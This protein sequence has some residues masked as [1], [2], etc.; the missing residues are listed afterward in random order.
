MTSTLKKK[1]MA[2]F[3]VGDYDKAV[4]YFQK[5]SAKKPKSTVLKSFL[6]RAKLKSYQAHVSMARKYREANRKEEAIKEYKFALSVFPLNVKLEDEFNAYAEIKRSPKKAFVSEINPPVNL[7]VDTK[8]KISIKLPAAPIKKIYNILGKSFNIN[9]IFDKDFRDFVYGLEIE[10][11]G[12][13]QILNQLCMVSNSRYRVLDSTSIMVYPDT[14]FKRRTFDLQ[15]VKVFYLSNVKVED[16]KKNLM[17][18]FRDQRIQAQEDKNLNSIII[19]ADHDTLKDIERFL[20]NIDKVKSEVEIDLQI[21][22]VNR[23]IVNEMGTNFGTP[24]L[25]VSAGTADAEGSI[26]STFNVND[27]GDTKFSI[28]IPSAA[29]SFLASDDNTKI[30]SKPNLRG[31][32]GEEIS[33]KVGEE[34]P[35]PQTSFQSI[36]AGGVS[37]VPMTTYT[38]KPV[39]VDVK[40]TP[41]VHQNNEVTL[42]LKLTLKSVIG[43]IDAFPILGNRELENIIRLKEGETNI[44]GGFIED[45][46]RGVLAGLPGFSK[47]PLLGKLFG[48]TRKEIKQK[49]L[50]FSITPRVIRKL[51][52]SGSNQQA[53]WLNAQTTPGGSSDIQPGRSP[54]DRE[55]KPQASAN[56]IMIA[57]TN[58]TIPVNSFAHFT[59][60]ANSSVDISTLNVSGSVEGPK[61]AIQELKTDIQKGG[62]KVFKNFSDNSFDIGVSN[63]GVGSRNSILGQVKVKFLQKGTYIIKIDS[64]NAT[65]K[66]GKNIEFETIT[67]E[68]K[69]TDGSNRPEDQRRKEGEVPDAGRRDDRRSEDE[70]I[71]ERN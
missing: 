4:E 35:V 23:N 36:A 5:E 34:R 49:D 29:L 31:V 41:H 22:E 70:K 68:I 30:I 12:F 62:A 28:T 38:Y 7:N 25:S 46:E 54:G 69:V 67:A 26:S 66:D 61:A 16:A 17:T 71:K 24:F 10:G 39:G 6:F 32:D 56:R 11:V 2:Y 33:F 14:T 57:P 13:Y 1:G 21:M 50:I 19:K 37:T 55:S 18:I 8:E 59:I 60:R 3:H 42:E 52:V 9:I 15:G 20:Y 27:I 44:V 65:T 53:I 45:E 40:I 48:G 58:R 63:M 47:I 51:D 64:T 43:Y